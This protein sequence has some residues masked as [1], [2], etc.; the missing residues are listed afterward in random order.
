MT[1]AA[2]S[3][4]APRG[5]KERPVKVIARNPKARHDYEILH[6]YEAGLVL[7]GTEVKTLRAGR[8]SI[9]GAFGRVHRG[10]VWI[11]GIQIPHYAQGN[12]HNHE[13]LRSRKLLMHKREIQRLIGAVQQNGH[14]LVPLELHFRGPTAKVVIALARGKKEHDKREDLKKREADREVARVF[15]KR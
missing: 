11:E 12:I 9:V 15:R 2:K 6:T 5:A 14:T 10:E 1:P 13:P 3:P 8:G 7:Q 4:P